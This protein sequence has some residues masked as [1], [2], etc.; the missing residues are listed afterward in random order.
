[1]YTANE[2]HEIST[3][4]RRTTTNPFVWLESHGLTEKAVEEYLAKPPQTG[5][6]HRES[7]FMAGVVLGVGIAQR[8]ANGREH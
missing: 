5:L 1:M 7:V 4:Q 3:E 6:A 8:E 2:L